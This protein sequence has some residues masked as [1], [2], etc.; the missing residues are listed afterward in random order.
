MKGRTLLLL[1]GCSLILCGNLHA[2]FVFPETIER[3]HPRLM[4][5]DVTRE[6][7][8]HEIKNSEEVRTSYEN[9]KSKIAGF[10]KQHETDPE[11]MVSRLQMYWKSHA[12]DVIVD[13]D[14]YSHA[15]GKAP[16]PTVRFNGKRD[17]ITD[18][19]IPKD[20][21]IIPYSED[22][23]GLWLQHKKTKNWEWVTPIESG[24][25]IGKINQ[26]IM[27]YA[28][29][30]ALIYYLE[31]DESYAKFAAHL[32]DTYMQGIYYRKPPYDQK[33]GAFQTLGG[34]TAFQ[35]IKELSVGH[36]ASCYDYL[37]YYLKENAVD[38]MPVYATSFK[39]MAEQI[40]KNGVPNNNWNLI[41]ADKVI[42]MAFILEDDSYYEDGRGA[43]HYLDRI[44]NKTEERQWSITKLLN[45]GYDE[46]TG[47]WDE[48]AGYSMLVTN[49]F[50][51]LLITMQDAIDVDILPYMPV[52]PKAVNVL[53]QY[54]FPNKYVIAF[55]DTHYGKVS[56]R[57]M[58]NM[59]NNA[60]KFGKAEQ[61]K[62][63]TAMAHMINEINGGS[64]NGHGGRSRNAFMSLLSGNNVN[65]DE[66]VPAANINDYI[67]STFYAPNV[68]WLAMRNG[69]D[70]K[71]GLMISQA[72]SLGNHMHSNG[73][74]MELYGKNYVLGVE[75][76]RGDSYHSANY[77]E[78]YSQFPAHNTVSVNG[79]SKYQ[80]MRSEHPFKVNHVYP[81]SERKTGF[82]PDISYSDLYFLEPKTNSDQNRVM[83][84]VRTG[85]TS[86]YYIDI[87]RSKTK[88][89]DD[90]YHD[91]FYH[92]LGQELTLT[93]TN[94]EFFSLNPS[95]KLSSKDGDLVAYDYITDKESIET[96]QD[97]KAK[98]ELSI[99]G[100]EKVTMNM[101]MKGE[102]NREVFS[103]KSPP[104]EAIRG[105]MVPDDIGDMPL[106]T[107]IIRNKGEA[108]NNP[109]VAVFE[110][111]N[112]SEPSTIKNISSFKATNA[113]ESFVGLKIESLSNRTDI[114]FSSDMDLPCSY[115]EMS[116]VGT[117]GVVTKD[118]SST[119]L[120]LGSGSEIKNGNYSI[121]TLQGNLT[122]AS[123]KYGDDQ[124]YFTADAPTVIT[125]TD[126]YK[127]GDVF[128]VYG[129]G[130]IKGERHKTKGNKTISFTVPALPYQKITIKRKNR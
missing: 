100:E 31:E 28:R 72:G 107:T 87:F 56:N 76:G 118:S 84:I 15:E 39:K 34:Y 69:F 50:A 89:E 66:K 54:L 128:L 93:N 120:F 27:G 63:Y 113:G 24:R 17:Y 4:S 83:S 70:P 127:K 23:R 32:F 74:A 111:A 13:G 11:W 112:E 61:E 29:D 103:A 64:S 116:I 85:E 117:Y 40:I 129:D 55:G 60:K 115:N 65:L 59:V 68:S 99:P 42:H 101:W 71:N 19:N 25:I 48:C 9:F 123:L 37:Y 110:P 78:Y 5:P 105:G 22:E 77:L 6:K 2:Q 109:F 98:F 88:G 102:A 43:Q 104:S 114:I 12:T 124:I 30:A 3:S 96:D 90:K 45:A 121:R 92:N 62:E 122:S 51:D 86:G 26:R 57:S 106:L 79:I 8:L 1:L 67:T 126:N 49:D 130:E 38:K 44:F 75:G 33:K 16:V 97:F 20:E 73:I 18:Y 52:I 82:F 47:I 21:D 95:E 108:W 94:N 81:E 10:V 36:L 125:I 35:V 7:I 58:L 91:Y 119:N 80:E 41:Q 53:P 46:N 14:F